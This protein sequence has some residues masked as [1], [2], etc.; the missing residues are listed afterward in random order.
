MLVVHVHVHVKNDKVETFKK[1][2]IE[3]AE[4]SIKEA[5]IARFDLIQDRE[6]PT[7]FILVEVYRTTEDTVRHKETDHYQKWRDT[8]EDMMV[9]PRKSIKYVNIFPDDQGWG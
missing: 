4:N 3:N 2:C 8:V 9:E 1:V 5:G 6:D 7:Q